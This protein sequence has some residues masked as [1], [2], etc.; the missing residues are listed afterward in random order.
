MAKPPDRMQ[1]V[2]EALAIVKRTYTKVL[3]QI[4]ELRW[5]VR[6]G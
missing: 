4:A 5:V 2:P 1:N 3:P 6:V